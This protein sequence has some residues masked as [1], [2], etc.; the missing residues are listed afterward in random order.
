MQ[1]LDSHWTDFREI[2]HPNIFR[3]SVLR[4]QVSLKLKKKRIM[5][6]LHKDVRTFIK[7]SR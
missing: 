7:A 1:Q 2:S 5:G 6:I 4:T 3:K